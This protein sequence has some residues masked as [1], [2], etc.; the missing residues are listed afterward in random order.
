LTARLRRYHFS[1]L[2]HWSGIAVKHSV[3]IAARNAK[4]DF[5]KVIFING[6][7]V[8]VLSTYISSILNDSKHVEAIV[9]MPACDDCRGAGKNDENYI[10]VCDA[11]SGVGYSLSSIDWLSHRSQVLGAVFNHNFEPRSYR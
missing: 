4:Q 5:N 10:S 3:T 8:R 7:R 2:E 6:Q 11:C 1:G 9:E